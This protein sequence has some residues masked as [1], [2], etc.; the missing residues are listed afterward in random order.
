MNVTNVEVSSKGFSDHKVISCT[1]LFK[2][3]KVSQKGHTTI[4]YRSF[5]KFN[6]QHFLFDLSCLDFNAIYN[7]TNADDAFSLFSDIFISVINKHAPMRQKRVKHQTLPAWLNHNIISA[8][9]L[10]DFYQ[11]NKMD[12]LYRS[13][14]NLVTQLLRDA[15]KGYFNSL[16]QQQKDT[17][18]I[19]RALNEMTNK[20]KVRNNQ[21]IYPSTPNSLNNY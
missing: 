2:L 11:H 21:N 13:Q 7:A 17:K 16:L 12:V 4:D 14:R 5:K 10:H 20:N 18:H 15:Q 19:W 3:S 6:E 8:M 1:W 9:E